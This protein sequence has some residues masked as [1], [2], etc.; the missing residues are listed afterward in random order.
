MSHH[1]PLGFFLV[2][3]FW[4]IIL[5]FVIISYIFIGFL[6]DFDQIW[7]ISN[8]FHI[9]MKIQYCQCDQ[10]QS[11]VLNNMCRLLLKGRFINFTW[12]TTKSTHSWYQVLFLVRLPHNL[13]TC[14]LS[15]LKYL[16]ANSR[17]MSW[18]DFCRSLFDFFTYNFRFLFCNKKYLWWH[19]L[20]FS[21]Q[22]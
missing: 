21:L 16:P 8:M 15:L 12:F 3:T 9:S 19:W 1:L 4:T 22:N 5:A 17:I 13:T 18:H 10:Q 2:L 20:R 11:N 6:D 14:S 7:L